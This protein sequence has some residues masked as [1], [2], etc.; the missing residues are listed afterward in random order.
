MLSSLAGS[1]M[2]QPEERM[3]NKRKSF[4]KKTGNPEG[5]LLES[6]SAL[7]QL[8]AITVIEAAGKQKLFTNRNCK[9]QFYLIP[10]KG[11][12]IMLTCRFLIML[13]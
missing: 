9:S 4:V 5:L 10:T 7:P 8:A 3:I 12:G 6:T 2:Q 1:W 11:E 13:I